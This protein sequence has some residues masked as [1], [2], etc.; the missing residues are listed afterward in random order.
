MEGLVLEHTRATERADVD[1]HG[2]PASASACPASS[3][4]R[5]ADAGGRRAVPSFAAATYPALPPRPFRVRSRRRQSLVLAARRFSSA[6]RK[7]GWTRAPRRREIPLPSTRHRPPR[8]CRRR[9]AD[10]RQRLG[11]AL[12]GTRRRPARRAAAAASAPPPPSSSAD[13][14]AARGSSPTDQSVGGVFLLVQPSST[15]VRRRSP[16]HSRCT[17]IGASSTRSRAGA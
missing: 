11:D 5:G 16:L 8:A 12:R 1:G 3:R 4:E 10:E 15:I 2:A 9:E 17:A 7:A 6:S 14:R 13:A